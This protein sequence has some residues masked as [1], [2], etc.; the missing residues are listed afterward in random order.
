MNSTR[1]ELMTLVEGLDQAAHT[2]RPSEEVW[3]IRDNLAHLADAERAHRRFVEVVLEGRSVHLEGFDLD[4]WN[5]EHVARRA[6]QSFDEILDALRVER[7]KTLTL[8]STLTPDDWE[9]RGD[10]PALGDVSVHQV[11]KVIGVHERMHLKEIR[12]LLKMQY[13]TEG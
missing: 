11:I 12:K 3:S 10:H 5:Q 7:Q 9:Q 13:A 4:R 6:D 1:D 2:W 8:I